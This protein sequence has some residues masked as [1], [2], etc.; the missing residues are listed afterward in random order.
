MS[1]LSARG[2]TGRGRIRRP[3]GALF[4]GVLAASAL[5][6][7]GLQIP[8]DPDGTL[9]RVSGDVLR[10]GASPEE[11]LVQE[12]GG[13]V[14]GTQADLVEKFAASMDAS[15]EWTVGSEETLVSKLEA[16]DLDLVVGGMTSATLWVGKAGISRG[17]PGIDGSDGRPLVWLVPLGENAFLS[18]IEY[19]LDDEVGG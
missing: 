15:V 1:P 5:T 12:Q 3:F 8:A 16:G 6:G 18:T 19:F 10:V 4:V 14:V 9:E 2:Q 13:E 17:Y 7:C 11:P